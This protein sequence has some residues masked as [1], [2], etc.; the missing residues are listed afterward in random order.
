MDPFSKPNHK[1]YLSNTKGKI[2]ESNSTYYTEYNKKL[3]TSC[4]HE[5]KLF[6]FK[7]TFLWYQKN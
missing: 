6:S 4:N 3:L 5:G 2:R 7:I 1:D